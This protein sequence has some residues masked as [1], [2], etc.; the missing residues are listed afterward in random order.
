MSRYYKRKPIPVDDWRKLTSYGHR[1]DA[2]KAIRAQLGLGLTDACRL[3]AET[4]GFE[5][6]S[7]LWKWQT[8][9]QVDFEM[10]QGPH[11]LTIL[12]MIAARHG[13][14]VSTGR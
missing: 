6:P 1:I 11:A 4:F 7:D 12:K 14:N 5:L 3:M 9:H 8:K 10:V 2:V 13:R